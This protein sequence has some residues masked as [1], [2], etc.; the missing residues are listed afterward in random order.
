MSDRI[1]PSQSD[2]PDRDFSGV[3]HQVPSVSGSLPA[4]HVTA[5]PDV[6]RF[7]MSARGSL[8]G[9]S[10]TGESLR[11]LPVSSGSAR[12]GASARPRSEE[13]TRDQVVQGGHRDAPPVATVSLI[14]QPED[15]RFVANA[16]KIAGHIYPI[17]PSVQGPRFVGMPVPTV[18]TPFVSQPATVVSQVAL[19]P[20]QVI[21]SAAGSFVPAFVAPDS[22]MGFVTAP[23]VQ[24]APPAFRRHQLRRRFRRHWLQRSNWLHRHH[25]YNRLPL[26]ITT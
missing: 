1:L 21:A 12:A 11:G 6:T 19:P 24:S 4:G 9:P 10:E 23:T 20:V 25:R 14:G 18:G 2:W 13:P 16:A 17:D 8:R 5:R 3:G 7:D 22:G 26:S 15:A